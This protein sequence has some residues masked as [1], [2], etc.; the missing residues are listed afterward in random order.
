MRAAM[1]RTRGRPRQYDE[2]QA[3]QAA[4]QVFWIK[5][6]RSTSLDDLS[7]AMG[8][9]RPSIYNAFGNKEALYRRA[10]QHFGQGM[11]AAFERTML[12]EEDIHVALASFYRAALDVY[13]SGEFPKGCMVMTTAVAAATAH[14]EIQADLLAI[15]RDLDEKIA[16]RLRRAIDDRQLPSSFDAA[17]RA[18]VAQA[19]L[20]TLSLRARAGDSR[21]QL[22]RI[23][24]SGVALVLSSP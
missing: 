5:G 3:L 18:S 11:E 10:L 2:A 21:A 22:D 24:E 9:N 8:M 15:V 16:L 4:A 6:L 19:I 13:T 14:P 7:V 23:A 1:K 12:G 17:E 20:H